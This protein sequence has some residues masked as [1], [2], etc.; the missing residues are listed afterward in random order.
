MTRSKVFF[1]LFAILLSALPSVAT[2][3][4][5]EGLLL[6]TDPLPSGARGL[7]MDG[8]L[9]SA[10]DGISALD[11][12]PA[13]LAPLASQEFSFSLFNRTH[14]S[15]ADFLG[16]S[17]TSS[18]NSTSF[19]GIGLATPFST[20]RGHFAMGVSFDRVRDYDGTYS[21][22]A[23]NPNSS[24]FN[25]QN[26]LDYQH[27]QGGATST[28]NRA[29]LESNNLAYAIGLT[30]GVPDSGAF[31]LSTPFKGGLQQLGTLTTEGG[32]NAI[33]IGGGIDIAEG[34]SAGA[35]INILFG[36]YDNTFQY[37]ETDVNGIFANDTNVYP[38]AHFQTATITDSY[39]Q[40]QSGA[41]LKL[42]LLVNR[43]I[44]RFGLTIETPQAL[45]INESWSRTGVAQFGGSYPQILS[46]DNTTGAF[47][48]ADE[49]DVIT[50]MRFGAGASV[51]V[52]GLTGALSV[53]YA[54]L[55]Q[56]RFNNSSFDMTHENDLA[57][58]SLRGVLSWNLGAEYVFPLLGLSVRAGY[59]VEPSPY[60]NDPSSYNTKTM[61]AG[62][63]ILLSKSILLEGSWRRSSYHTFHTIYNDLT[64]EGSTISAGISDD[65]VNRDDVAVTFNYR[66]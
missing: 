24:F 22:K 21:F 56:L 23:V 63:G 7:A 45:H 42:G 65:A 61:S 59:G 32:L 5:S 47:T 8:S 25:T 6:S 64:P 14:G 66:F 11:F 40:D 29:Y 51:H 10:A 13:A 4:F 17:S 49:Y 55:S 28:G 41:S 43:E 58:D 46:T 48:G 62:L 33:R 39:H 37:T 30:Y 1:S 16:S 36:S 27:A 57:R 3:Q 60:K 12:N 38:P 34:V 2:A 54:D 15:T 50:P 52:A 9:I 19:S 20:T 53:S 44:F 31:T 26:F 18:I 35:T